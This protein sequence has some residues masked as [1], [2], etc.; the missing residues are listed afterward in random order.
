MIG[1]RGISD[2][3]PDD[4]RRTSVDGVTKE[5]QVRQYPC[6]RTSVCCAPSHPSSAEDTLSPVIRA[7]GAKPAAL[8]ARAG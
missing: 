3:P 4:T 7:G 5:A 6:F 2:E 8:R 1:F